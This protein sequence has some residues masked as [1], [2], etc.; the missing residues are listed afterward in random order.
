MAV[1]AGTTSGLLSVK[2]GCCCDAGV[3]DAATVVGGCAPTPQPVAS[4]ART[5]THRNKVHFKFLR[6]IL[7]PRQCGG[8]CRKG[9]VQGPCQ[10][11]VFKIGRASCRERV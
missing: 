5:N 2:G 4:P 6:I 11:M 10:K 7:V 1:F 3:S 9:R 8:H